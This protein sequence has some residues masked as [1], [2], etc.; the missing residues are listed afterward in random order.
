M[1][2][3]FAISLISSFLFSVYQ[4]KVMG[5]IS[6]E[7]NIDKEVFTMLVRAIISKNTEEFN[8]LEREKIYSS[9]PVEKENTILEDVIEKIKSKTT[10]SVSPSLEE[11]INPQENGNNK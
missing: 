4:T 9:A 3:I 5:K 8:Q 6:G 11:Y 7:N 10:G 1:E 2:I